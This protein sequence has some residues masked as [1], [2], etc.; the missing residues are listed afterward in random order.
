MTSREWTAARDAAAK[1]RTISPR[2]HWER[3]EPFDMGH[4]TECMF[5]PRKPHPTTGYAI[6]EIRGRQVEAHRP[7]YKELIGPIPDDLELDHLCRQRA[8][9]NPWHMEPVTHR[10]NALRGYGVGALAARKRECRKG[11]PFNPEN[12]YIHPRGQRV[13]RTCQVE[14]N[15]RGRRRGR[16]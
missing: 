1:A 15:R 4:S 11:H 3:A 9:V 2:E 14:A 13:C 8:C 10:V 16:A 7:I 6:I 12:T 5:L